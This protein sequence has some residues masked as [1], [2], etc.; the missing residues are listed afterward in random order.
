MSPSSRDASAERGDREFQDFQIERS[1]PAEMIGDG[2]LIG[3]RALGDLRTEA[4]S[5]PRSAK[6]LVA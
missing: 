2:G 3:L 6:T 4:A 1:L 5:N